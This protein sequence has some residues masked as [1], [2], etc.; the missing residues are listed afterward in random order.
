MI[1]QRSILVPYSDQQ[2]FDIV[3]D[4]DSY[5]EFLPWCAHSEVLSSD[6]EDVE[7]SLKVAYKNLSM[8][9]STRNKHRQPREISMQLKSGP[10]SQLSGA[11]SFQHLTDQACK[12][13]LSLEFEFESRMMSRMFSGAF[14]QIIISQIAAFEARAKQIY[15]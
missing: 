11:W 8:T 10:F 3:A 4:I 9:F 12:I 1:V 7:A 13:A 6:G 15:R 2:M 14:E 5:D